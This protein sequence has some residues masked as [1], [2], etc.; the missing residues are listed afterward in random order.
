MAKKG[1]DLAAS[2]N[3]AM[4]KGEVSNLDTM[5]IEY[6]DYDLI[7]SNEKN[8]YELS[9]LQALANSIALD[10]LQQP[11]V[12]STS[13]ADPSRVLLISGHR[14]HAAIG[15]LIHDEE[16]PRPDLRRVPFLRREY[17]DSDLMELQL[18]LANSTSRVLTSAETMR[19]V[20]RVTALLY[21]LKSG[22]HEF[23]G[24]MRAQVAE[25]CNISE[26]KIQRVNTIRKG[27]HE[28]FMPAYESGKLSEQA[29]VAI[30]K[31]PLQM[32]EDLA[33]L[34]KSGGLNAIV[35][36]KMLAVE[37]N[38]SIPVKKCKSGALC[39][40]GPQFLAHDAQSSATWDMCKGESCCKSCHRNNN[41]KFLCPSAKV[42]AQERSKRANA[43]SVKR[44]KKQE[45]EQALKFEKTKAYCERFASAMNS[46]N[47]EGSDIADLIGSYALGR[48]LSLPNKTSSD[49]PFLTEFYPRA[50]IFAELCIRFGCSADWLL[51]LSDSPAAAAPAAG[52]WVSHYAG[53]PPEGALVAVRRY[54]GGFGIFRYS[55]IGYCIPDDPEMAPLNVQCKSYC[56]LPE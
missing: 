53:P 7:D 44:K 27:L 13:P 56:V 23:P 25:A 48:I 26:G 55:G 3:Q 45:E 15:M 40:N 12:A 16:S 36:E 5:R 10:G 30:A 46:G 6:I 1:F 9:D 14:R 35:A 19:Q 43:E 22:G 31:M 33:I 54:N 29:A 41:C 52:E 21:K 20:E 39:T 49:F 32:Q 11:L 47:S 24:K 34:R 37:Q 2:V 17:Q 50:D 4:G 51:G 28:S 42:Q 8:F 18:I 38:Y